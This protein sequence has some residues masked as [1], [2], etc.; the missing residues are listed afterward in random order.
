M[1]KLKLTLLVLLTV[2]LVALGA[3]LPKIA[4]YVADAAGTDS[5]YSREMTTPV[6]A[7][8]S[9][10]RNAQEDILY[11]LS[12]LNVGRLVSVSP[13]VA[14]HDEEEIR[15]VAERILQELQSEEIIDQEL[16][17]NPLTLALA[18][19]PNDPSS[20]YFVWVLRY[21]NPNQKQ[22]YRHLE[23][24]LDDETEAILSI[25]YNTST[26]M[27]KVQARMDALGE[28]YIT[29]L[30]VDS[31]RYMSA[32]EYHE[33]Y[34]CWSFHF[35]DIE[36]VEVQIIMVFEPLFI[37]TTFIQLVAGNNVS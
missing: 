4:T 29:G 28:L 26:P 2:C 37:E 3:L 23:I 6:I 8:P 32:A 18:V 9:D 7:M 19:D 24:V 35:S 13:D 12:I 22:E 15:E 21:S 30:G 11:K 5:I 27:E 10:E 1:N 25:S 33:N 34:A 16:T 36:G 17:I 20:Y 31:S 14:T